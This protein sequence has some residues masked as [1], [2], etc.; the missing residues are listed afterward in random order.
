MVGEVKK[1][2]IPTAKSAN[3]HFVELNFFVLMLL[4]GST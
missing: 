3:C 4:E 1:R 2:P